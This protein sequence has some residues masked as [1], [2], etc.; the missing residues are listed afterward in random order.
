MII[1]NGQQYIVG[2]SRKGNGD[3][4]VSHLYK[5]DFHDPGLPMCRHGWNDG[6]SYSIFRENISAKGICKVCMRRAEAGLDG[7]S[8]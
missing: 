2:M 8:I 4:V 6:D 3:R 1:Y 7:V 5:G